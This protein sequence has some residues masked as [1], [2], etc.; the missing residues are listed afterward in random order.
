VFEVEC[1]YSSGSSL[2]SLKGAFQSNIEAKSPKIP[3]M[4][5]MAIGTNN[6]KEEIAI[7]KAMLEK[8]N[9]DSKEK[10]AHIKLQEEKIAK[11]TTKLETQLVRS[12]T[13]DLKSEEEEKASIHTK[14]SNDEVYLKKGGKL[15]SDYS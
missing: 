2:P 15:R 14:V 1:H 13:R 6:W 10:E 5:A 8:L 4:L 7:M 12:I 11:L 3:I 9:K